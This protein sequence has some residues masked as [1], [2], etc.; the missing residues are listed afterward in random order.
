MFKA[1][2]YKPERKVAVS[3]PVVVFEI[4]HALN[5]FGYTTALESNQPPKEMCIGDITLPP[6]CAD[7]LKILGA[8]VS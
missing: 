5:S 6:S 2:H 3:K 4:F 1:F 8:S 7:F